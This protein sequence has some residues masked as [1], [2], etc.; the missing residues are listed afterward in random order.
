VSTW[1][2]GRAEFVHP[3]LR[4]ASMPLMRLS[5]VVLFVSILQHGNSGWQIAWSVVFVVS[6]VA[7]GL[8]AILRRRRRARNDDNPTAR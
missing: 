6:V 2:F 3:A 1:L 8:N 5:M 7:T 4:W